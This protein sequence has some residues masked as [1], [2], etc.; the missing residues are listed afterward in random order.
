MKGLDLCRSYFECIRP[1]I[2]EQIPEIGDSYAAGLIGWGSDVLGHDDEWSRDHEWGPRC[3][4]FLPERLKGH[5][6]S[7]FSIL[8]ARMPAE[9]RG[10]LTRFLADG[11]CDGVRVP[12]SD[13]SAEVHI[14][15]W[16]CDEYL[17]HY[18]GAARPKDDI[19]WLCIPEQRL[20]EFTRGDVFFDGGED[21]AFGGEE[22]IW[23][24]S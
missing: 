8:N 3:L 24:E 2:A 6:E 11:D 12:S 13:P 23:R 16:T 9:H 22:A 18:M 15:I 10:F 7:T 20:L 21:L 1:V 14:Q 4:V 5:R 17:R 19:D